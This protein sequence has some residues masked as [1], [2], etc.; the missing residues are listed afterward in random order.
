MK[1]YQYDACFNLSIISFAWKINL[2]VRCILKIFSMS[3]VDAL[4]DQTIDIF[5]EE[6]KTEI[7][8]FSRIV[9]EIFTKFGEDLRIQCMKITSW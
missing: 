8:I 6:A 7:I 9:P 4:F 1:G 2:A 5:S 3:P